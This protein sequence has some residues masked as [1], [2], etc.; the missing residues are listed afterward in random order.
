M[1]IF[2]KG[3]H[4]SEEAAESLLSVLRLFKDRYS[5][6]QFRQIHLSLVLVDK[7][8]DEVELVDDKTNKVY[9]NLEIY[10][11]QKELLSVKNPPPFLHLVVDNT[12]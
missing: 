1:E 4:N 9:Q 5:I 8:G 3:E 11:N 6:S 10:H 2:L 12:K 7:Q